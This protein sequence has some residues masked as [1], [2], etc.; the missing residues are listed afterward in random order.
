VPYVF[1]S[2]FI[3]FFLI[4][5]LY[6]IGYTG[7]MSLYSARGFAPPQFSGFANYPGFQGTALSDPNRH[8]F[9]RPLAF[10]AAGRPIFQ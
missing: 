8:T 10:D 3:L 7:Y 4:F 2:P 9:L 1:A 6:P 5:F